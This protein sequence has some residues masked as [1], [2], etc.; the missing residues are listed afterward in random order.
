MAL[1]FAVA[2][3]LHVRNEDPST[4]TPKRESLLRIWW[5]LYSLDRQL[6]IITGRPSVVVDSCCSVPLPMPFP[7]DE[8][9]DDMESLNRLRRASTMSTSTSISTLAPTSPTYTNHYSTGGMDVP[10]TPITFPISGAN[11]GSF[12]RAVVQ[13]GT[14]T[15][16]ILSSLYTAGTMI[17]P[18]GELQQDIA[19]LNRRLDEWVTALPAEFDFR[20]R[21]SGVSTPTRSHFRERT[22]LGFQFYSAKILLTRPYFSGGSQSRKEAKD[23]AASAG[24]SRPTSLCVDAAKKEV[25]MLPDQPGPFFLWKYGPWW[26]IVHYLMQAL[27]VL[28]LALDSS[29]TS[30]HDRADLATYLKKIVRSLRCMNDMTARTAYRIAFRSFDM[31]AKRASIPMDDM[32]A[33]HNLHERNTGPDVMGAAN[34]EFGG[35]QMDTGSGY[36]PSVEAFIPIMS[37]SGPPPS[38]VPTSLFPNPLAMPTAFPSHSGGPLVNDSFYHPNN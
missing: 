26:C 22:L 14:I 31:V 17:R 27:A 11:P 20:T 28:L 6:S 37:I 29:T 36:G 9:T 25:D 16:S 13:M 3:G 34:M 8:I 24:I 4:S 10:R 32:W 1:R 35:Y 15:Q 30:S 33:E 21:R 5:A 18:S 38:I 12:F 7:E 19:L 23:V 2:L